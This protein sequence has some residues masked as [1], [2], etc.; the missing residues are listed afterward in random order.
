VTAPE[1]VDRRSVAISGHIM[2]WIEDDLRC[3][4]SA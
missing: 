1:V 4:H 2:S 3:S